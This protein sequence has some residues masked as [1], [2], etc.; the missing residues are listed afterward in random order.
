MLILASA[1]D[2]NPEI[3][4]EKRFS[5]RKENGENLS[6]FDAVQQALSTQFVLAASDN[7]TKLSRH[8]ERK[9]T[10]TEQHITLWQKRA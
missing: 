7:I 4:A 1:Y 6:G 8:C 5:G 3:K 10:L 9:F 2:L